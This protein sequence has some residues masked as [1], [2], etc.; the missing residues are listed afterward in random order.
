MAR[1]SALSSPAGDGVGRRISSVAELVAHGRSG[2]G[3]RTPR[4]GSSRPR[5]PTGPPLTGL[6]AAASALGRGTVAA[7]PGPGSAAPRRA[8]DAEE[9]PF[10]DEAAGRPCGLARPFGA[11][12]DVPA[13]PRRGRSSIWRPAPRTPP[14]LLKNTGGRAATTSPSRC[15]RPNRGPPIPRA[16]SGGGGR[17]PAAPRRPRCPAA[18]TRSQ[19]RAS[20]ETPPAAAAKATSS[21]ARSASSPTQSA[22][23]SRVTAPSRSRA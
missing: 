23:I 16:V 20:S 9:R 21:R 4:P 22:A 11:Q 7:R 8:G 6:P 2:R 3:T 17:A 12:R 15:C 5:S 18:T 1:S 13:P 19:A 10:A 14:L